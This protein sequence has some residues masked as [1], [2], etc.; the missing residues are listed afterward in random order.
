MTPEDLRGAWRLL[1]A[2]PALGFAEG[3]RMVFRAPDSLEYSFL[4][5]GTRH[6]VDLA[7]RLE[8]QVLRTV[9]V[10][11]TH[12]AA[13]GIEFGPGHVLVLDFGGLRAWLVRELT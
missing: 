13:A 12:E 5:G 1:R 3:V 9:V 4:A 8:G 7:Y 11:T 2:D 6:V 10:G